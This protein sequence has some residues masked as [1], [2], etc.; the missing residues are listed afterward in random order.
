MHHP[1]A[2]LR[3]LQ[4]DSDTNTVLLIPMLERSSKLF[5]NTLYLCEH[6]GSNENISLGLDSHLQ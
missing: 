2:L 1:K 6:I 4:F 3:C 5:Y